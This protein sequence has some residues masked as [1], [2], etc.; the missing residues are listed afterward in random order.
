MTETPRRSLENHPLWPLY[1]LIDVEQWMNFQR[2]LNGDFKDVHEA[3]FKIFLQDEA[4]NR[5]CQEI[6]S[7]FSGSNTVHNASRSIIADPSARKEYESAWRK[8]FLKARM[9]PINED[10]SLK[11]IDSLFETWNKSPKI[12]IAFSLN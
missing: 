7:D 8:L 9:E 1:K 4:K 3:K 6:A 12:T 10:V 5:L 2:L 11:E